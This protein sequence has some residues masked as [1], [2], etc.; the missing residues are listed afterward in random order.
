MTMTSTAH[1]F[2]ARYRRALLDRD[3]QAMGRLY[4]VPALIVFPGQLVAVDDARTTE[5]F[6][7][8]SW[9]Q[10]DGVE[11]VDGKIE[12]VDEAPGTLWV[13]VTWSYGGQARERFRYQLVATPDGHRIAVLTPLELEST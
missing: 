2:F 13:D 11:D 12:A 3:E 10:Y 4:S 9:A 8:S 6:F 7:A 1:E 5:A